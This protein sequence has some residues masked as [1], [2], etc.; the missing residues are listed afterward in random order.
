M[1]IFSSASPTHDVINHSRCVLNVDLEITHVPRAEQQFRTPSV[2]GP[3]TAG[4]AGTASHRRPSTFR[5]RIDFGSKRELRSWFWRSR[6]SR[7]YRIEQ[8]PLPFSCGYTHTP[9]VLPYTFDLDVVAKE[10]TAVRSMHTDSTKDR[11]LQQHQ[12]RKTSSS[13]A[14]FSHQTYLH[15]RR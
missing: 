3:T 7:L 13:E 15:T 14:Q 10:A 5:G 6:A 1:L 11:A 4:M 12:V 8:L 9:I 2:V